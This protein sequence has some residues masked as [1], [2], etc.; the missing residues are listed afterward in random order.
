MNIERGNRSFVERLAKRKNALEAEKRRE[1]AIYDNMIS[2]VKKGTDEWA[3]K[4]YLIPSAVHN[5]GIKAPPSVTRKKRSFVEREAKRKN[6]QEEEKRRENAIFNNMISK[7]KK[8]TDEWAKKGY[9]VPSLPK[10]S[11][12]ITRKKKSWLSGWTGGYT[13][14]KRKHN[15]TGGHTKRKRRGMT[16]KGGGKRPCSWML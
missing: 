10:A 4:E 16:M 2:K 7:V 1:S 11:P 15:R 5:R 9:M 3:R 6:A 14:R 13:K 8:G 12:S